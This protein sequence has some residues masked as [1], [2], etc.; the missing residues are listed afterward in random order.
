MQNV[1]GQRGLADAAS[2]LQSY[3]WMSTVVENSMQFIFQRRPRHIPDPRKGHIRPHPAHN[4]Q[5]WARSRLAGRSS[6]KGQYPSTPVLHASLIGNVREN[7]KLLT[8]K[9]AIG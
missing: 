7:L 6:L 5:I 2:S 9:A 3:N 4:I 8:A 1:K